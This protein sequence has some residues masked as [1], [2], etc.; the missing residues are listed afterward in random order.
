MVKT[1]VEQIIGSIGLKHSL[2]DDD[3]VAFRRMVNF[4]LKGDSAKSL[5]LVEQMSLENR[6][7]YEAFLEFQTWELERSHFSERR[8]LRTG[9]WVGF[10]VSGEA[11]SRAKE[12]EQKDPEA[13]RLSSETFLVR[14][15]D[16]EPFE[17]IMAFVLWDIG[18][19][20]VS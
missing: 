12:L 17:A 6:K 18:I 14:E 8:I 5:G 16:Q 1:K 10:G 9:K 20:T 4:Y 2:N 19:I 3:R 15:A 11:L 13:Y 7:A